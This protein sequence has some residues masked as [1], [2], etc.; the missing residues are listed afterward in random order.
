V[1]APAQPTA[2]HLV[3]FEQLATSALCDAMDELALPSALPGLVPQR[4]G[5]G[6]VVGRAMTV[7]FAPVDQDPSAYR[8]GGGVGRPLEQVLQTMQ[9][10][11]VVVMDLGGTRTASAWG[12]LASRIA[13]S[14]GVRGTIVHGTCR[15]IDEIDQLGYPVW[16][17]GTFPRRSRNDFSFGSL[18]EPVDIGGV[19]VR[20]GDIVVADRTGVVCVPQAR[21]E[22]VLLLAQQITAAEQ[23]L[24]ARIDLDD[25]VDWDSV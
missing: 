2:E 15:D 18:R 24:A 11:D 4:P 21:F 9:R 25:V 16:A 1:L 19:T 5:Q 23:E 14:R 22:E 3:A 6:T 8:F 7:R 20:T 17:M 13:Q 12:G 10:G